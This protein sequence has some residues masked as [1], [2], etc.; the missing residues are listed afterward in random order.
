[1]KPGLSIVTLGVADLGRSRAF[2]EALGF[3]ASPASQGDVVFF[4]AGGVVLALYPVSLLAEDAQS[5]MSLKT[6]GVTLAW[7]L[8]DEASVE[9]AYAAALAAGAK[10]LK[11]PQSAEWGGFHAYV[12]DP[13]GHPWEIAHNPFFPLEADGRV[14]LP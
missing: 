9:A 7:N 11:E 8:P 5:P 6:P 12:A 3:A 14:V 13:D 1:M 2:Y 10:P 4:Q